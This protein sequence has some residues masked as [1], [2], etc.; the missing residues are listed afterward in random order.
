MKESK[1]G[2]YDIER[3]YQEACVE[4]KRRLDIADYRGPISIEEIPNKGKGYVATED[5]AKGTLLLAEKAFSCAFDDEFEGTLICI[6]TI[7]NVI[8]DPEQLLTTLGVIHN[9]RYNPSKTCQFYSLYAGPGF[10]RSNDQQFPEGTILIYLHC[11]NFNAF[12]NLELVYGAYR[13]RRHHS[14]LIR[15]V[16]HSNLY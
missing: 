2:I 11:L 10:P 12:R 8:Q 1:E 6:D 7:T 9:L 16:K 3:L 4:K 13:H 5:I 14:F 15:N